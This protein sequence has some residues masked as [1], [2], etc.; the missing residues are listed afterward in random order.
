MNEKRQTIRILAIAAL[1]IAVAGCAGLNPDHFIPSP[2]TPAPDGNRYDGSVNVQAFLPDVSRGKYYLSD[3]GKA[4]AVVPE[5]CRH[6][7]NLVKSD[8]KRP[9]PESCRRFMDRGEAINFVPD[10][11]GPPREELHPGQ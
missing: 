5:I 7:N 10:D 11:I 9:V 8:I 1:T 4:R 2:I 3:N 6:T